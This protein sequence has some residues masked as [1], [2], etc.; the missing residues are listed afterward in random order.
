[1]YL[2]IWRTLNFVCTLLPIKISEIHFSLSNLDNATIFTANDGR[3][4]IELL[5]IPKNKKLS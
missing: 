3:A 2:K 4:I 1:M 5:C